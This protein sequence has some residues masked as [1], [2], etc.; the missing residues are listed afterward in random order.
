MLSKVQ[1]GI[2]CRV[3]PC[4]SSNWVFR[5]KAIRTYMGIERKDL[6]P[7]NILI[8]K[9]TNLSLAVKKIFK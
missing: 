6:F 3:I 1:I 5:I 4:Q 2:Y 7:I 9:Y 8:G